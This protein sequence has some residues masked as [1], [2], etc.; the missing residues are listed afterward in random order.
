MRDEGG[1]LIPLFIAAVCLVAMVKC[2][3][4]DRARCEQAGGQWA[5]RDSVCVQ[6]PEG[7]EP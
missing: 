5:W 4:G 1:I 2:T 7:Y 3:E 6:P